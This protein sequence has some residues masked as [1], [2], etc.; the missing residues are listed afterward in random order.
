MT[1][2]SIYQNVRNEN[3][4][5]EIHN[6]GHY[7]NIVRQYLEWPNGVK[8]LVGDRMFHRWKKKQPARTAGRILSGQTDTSAIIKNRGIPWQKQYVRQKRTAL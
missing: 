2:I 1:T 8:H 6:D 3:K 4:F 7:H 5:L